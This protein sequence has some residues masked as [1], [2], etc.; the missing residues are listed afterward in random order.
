MAL[1]HP[2]AL[3]T[4]IQ[5]S[6]VKTIRDALLSAEP[7]LLED[8]LKVSTSASDAAKTATEASVAILQHQFLPTLQL[9]AAAGPFLVKLFERLIDHPSDEI[10]HAVYRALGAGSPLLDLI[11]PAKMT[12]FAEQVREAFKEVKGG[13][14]DP[15]MLILIAI[16]RRMQRWHETCVVERR[17]PAILVESS[18]TMARARHLEEMFH[19]KFGVTAAHFAIMQTVAACSQSLGFPPEEALERLHLVSDFFEQ[20]DM[21]ILKKVIS[22]KPGL[23][24]KLH[25]KVNATPLSPDIRLLVRLS[26]VNAATLTSA[27]FLR[28]R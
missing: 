24:A 23:E 25:E 12:S 9:P 26:L 4:L 19:G 22:R 11:A 16:L 3:E 10:A 15:L 14:K 27:V 21:D 1:Q 5:L 20:V 28:I 17:D 8:L 13:E 18:D 6:H 2:F 7:R